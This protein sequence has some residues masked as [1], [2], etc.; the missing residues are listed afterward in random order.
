[1]LSIHRGE[2]CL[3]R[4]L[5]LETRPTPSTAHQPCAT[6]GHKTATTFATSCTTAAL[7]PTGK[8]FP[9]RYYRRPRGLTQNTFPS[10]DVRQQQQYEDDDENEDAPCLM[11]FLVPSRVLYCSLRCR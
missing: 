5:A 9:G 1:M 4:A 6:M 10:E 11:F 7:S 3:L 2:E 8:T